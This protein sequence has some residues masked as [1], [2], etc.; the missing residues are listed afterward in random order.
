[1]GVE[2]AWTRHSL[3]ELAVADAARVVLTNVAVALYAFLTVA[4]PVMLPAGVP[5][6]AL[7]AAL[8]ART[9]R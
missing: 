7:F 6:L 2:T 5:L 1:M 8:I 9:P 3:A 4:A